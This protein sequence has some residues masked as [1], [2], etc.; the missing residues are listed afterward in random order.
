MKP[1]DRSRWLEQCRDLLTITPAPDAGPRNQ[2]ILP[3][4]VELLEAAQ[5]TASAVAENAIDDF[6]PIPPDATDRLNRILDN[7]AHQVYMASDVAPL[8]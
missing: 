3:F 6:R 4:L 1:T 2:T 7:I 8:D 5:D